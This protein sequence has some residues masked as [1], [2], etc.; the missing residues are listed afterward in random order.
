MFDVGQ[1]VCYGHRRYV[2]ILL[3]STLLAGDRD[4]FPVALPGRIEG[5]ATNNPELLLS[6]HDNLCVQRLVA[7]SADESAREYGVDFAIFKS[8]A[9]Q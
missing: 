3:S 9:G 4:H 8:D 6:V 1:L 5:I 7:G 2:F